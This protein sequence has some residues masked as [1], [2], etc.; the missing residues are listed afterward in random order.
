MSKSD[1]TPQ[2]EGRNRIDPRIVEILGPPPERIPKD[3]MQHKVDSYQHRIDT[4]KPELEAIYERLESH[5]KEQQGVNQ[6]A[7]EIRSRINGLRVQRDELVSE[8]K[9]LEDLKAT[10]REEMDASVHRNREMRSKFKFKSEGEIQDEINRLQRMQSTTSMTLNQEKKLLK[11]IESLQ[12]MKKEL[13]QLGETKEAVEEKKMEQKDVFSRLDEVRG[14]IREMNGTL[15]EYYEEI[16]KV[17]AQGDNSEVTELLEKRNELKGEIKEMRDKIRSEQDVYYG[18]QRAFR[19]WMNE[20]KGLEEEERKKRQEEAEKRR[21]EDIDRKTDEIF[22]KDPF[23][24]EKGRCDELI[25]YLQTLLRS[26]HGMNGEGNQQLQNGQTSSNR[27][28]RSGVREGRRVEQIVR[29]KRL[30]RDDRSYFATTPTSNET[31]RNNNSTKRSTKKGKKK[32]KKRNKG[33]NQDLVLFQQ[34]QVEEN[35]SVTSNEE[36]SQKNVEEE[37]KEEGERIEVTFVMTKSFK[38]LSITPVFI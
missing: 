8:R 7:N 15:K 20:K 36:D 21:Q 4:L 9:T 14:N 12:G 33:G 22:N 28:F 18:N 34:T 17:R 27:T 3:T 35:V 10:L 5:S 19:E 23:V 37:E 13:G 30:A 25:E 31:S 29:M 11:D 6:V 16:D 24:G 32:N 38:K 2:N 1:S 26:S